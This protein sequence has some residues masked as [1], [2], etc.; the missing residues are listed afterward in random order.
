VPVSTQ[1]PDDPVVFGTQPFGAFERIVKAV[2]APP[3]TTIG[4]LLV[5]GA[6]GKIDLR[7]ANAPIMAVIIRGCPSPKL[8]AR[9][10][11]I[12]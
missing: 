7:I 6:G 10:E 11:S 9:M 4:V 12:T 1:Y 5:A 8:G 2:I 3:R